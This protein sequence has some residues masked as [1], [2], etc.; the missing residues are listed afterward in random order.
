MNSDLC[1]FLQNPSRCLGF[2]DSED[3]PPPMF[4]DRF[5][6]LEGRRK[7][8]YRLRA[9]SSVCCAQLPREGLR[10]RIR[11]MSAIGDAKN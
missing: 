11:W 2:F 1:D 6:W 4:R 8:I 7:D 5:W 10:A 3:L 9:A